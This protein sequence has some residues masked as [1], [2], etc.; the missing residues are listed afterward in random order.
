M[1]LS[2]RVCVVSVR[3]CV[4]VCP[5]VCVCV[6]VC[7]CMVETN[8]CIHVQHVLFSPRSTVQP[9]TIIILLLVV[10]FRCTHH[11]SYLCK[12]TC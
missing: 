1:Y 3:V 9:C 7:V 5:C 6:C 4:C 12:K 8:V 10:M 2:V 11:V